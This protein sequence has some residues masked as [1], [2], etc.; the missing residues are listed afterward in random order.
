MAE[1]V[2]KVKDAVAPAINKLD[3]YLNTPADKAD[4]FVKGV[5]MASDKTGLGRTSLVLGTLS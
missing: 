1:Y 3:N 4:P 2:T 5:A